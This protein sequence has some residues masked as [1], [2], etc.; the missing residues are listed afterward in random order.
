MEAAAA[1]GYD[2]CG[3]ARPSRSHPEARASREWFHRPGRV[4]GEPTARAAYGGISSR[5][6][7]PLSVTPSDT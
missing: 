6:R 7:P 1:A 2:P 5:R 4:L 3:A